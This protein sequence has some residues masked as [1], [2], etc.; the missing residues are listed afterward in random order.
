M[1]PIPIVAVIVILSHIHLYLAYSQQSVYFLLTKDWRFTK[2][3]KSTPMVWTEDSPLCHSRFS[4]YHQAPHPSLS[5]HGAHKEWLKRLLCAGN[6]G[7]PGEIKISY[8]IQIDA[9]SA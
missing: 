8:D 3:K 5:I 4:H 6:S 7:E 1:S 9:G 2:V